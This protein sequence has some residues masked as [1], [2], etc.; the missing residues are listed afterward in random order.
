MIVE[1]P[2]RVERVCGGGSIITGCGCSIITMSF[3]L[4]S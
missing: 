4:S 2:G 3:S 1:S